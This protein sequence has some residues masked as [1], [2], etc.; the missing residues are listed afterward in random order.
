MEKSLTHPQKVNLVTLRNPFDPKDRDI[1]V[2]PYG[3]ETLVEIAQ[4]HL[5]Q[6][7]SFA[8][9]V[10][11]RPVPEEYL[12]RVILS[13]GDY[14]VFAPR[15]G[16]GDA[17]QYLK[18]VA[19]L[20]VAVALSYAFPYGMPLWQ[21][22]AISAIAMTAASITLNYL[23]PPP[24]PKIA[25]MD[26]L[27]GDASQVFSWNP[28]TVQQQ[29]I[30]IPHAYG[31]NR[32]YGNI[33]GAYLE[34]EGDKQ[35]LN[36]LI[37]LAQGPFKR[38]WDFRINDQP[39]ENMKGIEIHTRL[40][41]L[42]QNPISFFANSKIEYPQS[43]KVAYGS[44]IVYTTIRDDFDGMEIDLSC[45]Q[46]LWYAN[47]RGG[48]D[49]H[50]IDV[51][52]R[53][54][55]IGGEWET[56][57]RQAVIKNVLVSGG[58]W[59]LGYWV[60]DGESGSK[61]W[62]QAASGG[63]GVYDHYDG[64]W[65]A[66][67]RA[68]WRWIQG[69]Y[70]DAV[71]EMHDYFT[72]GGSAQAPVR[73]TI[74]YDHVGTA[75]K[76]K[77]E[78][79]KLSADQDSSRYGD[80]L[81][82]TSVREVFYDGQTYPRRVLVGIRALAT[83]QL[84]GSLRFSCLGEGR[85]VRVWDGESWSVD[86][87]H[88]AAWVLYDIFTQPVFDNSLAVQRY[89]GIDPSRFRLADFLEL[90]GYLAESVPDGKGG[91]EERLTFNGVFDMAGSMWEA[92][93][94]ICQEARCISVKFGTSIGLAI[95][96]P[97]TPVQLFTMGNIKA[98]SFKQFWLPQQERATEIEISF[99]DGEKDFA[100]QSFLAYDKT[101]VK[102]MPPA[103]ISLLGCTS[104]SEA[105][106]QAMYRLN[107][108][109]VLKRGVS[110]AADIDAVAC[111]IGD[112]IYIQH[113]VPQWGWGNRI[114]SADANSITLDQEV[115]IEAGKSY[116]VLIRI[117]AD[118][119][120]AERTITNS[121]GTYSVLNV[122]SPFDP[123]PQKHDLYWFGWLTGESGTAKPFRVLDVSRAQELTVEITAIEYNETVFN[124]DEDEPVFETP[125]YSA[126][127]T[128]SPVL[129]LN[130]VERLL[131][132]GGAI[133]SA[134]DVYFQRPSAATFDH[135]EIW[136]AS[137]EMGG[138]NSGWRFAGN[139]PSGYLR[140]ENVSEGLIYTVKAISV[141]SLGQRENFDKAPLF[142]LFV[143]G[144][145]ALPADVAEMWFEAS[146]G[147]VKLSW[148]PIEDVDL[149]FYRIKWHPDS[150]VG[151]WPAALAV[152][153]TK[154]TSLSLPAARDGIYFV[155]AVDT[156]GN[157]S[158]NAKS[159]ITTI[160]SILAW[161]VQEEMTHGPDWPGEMTG[162]VAVAGKLFLDAGGS[163][164]DIDDI[165]AI[166]DWD[167]GLAEAPALGYYELLAVDLGSVQT[168][169]SWG[170]VVFYPV[171]LDSLF[172]DIQDF[173]AVDNFDQTNIAGVGM[174]LQIA[175]SQDGENWGDWQNFLVGDYTAQSF[176]FRLKAWSDF[177]RRYVYAESLIF[178]IDMPDR[179]EKGDDVAVPDIGLP[180]VF[181]KPFMARPQVGI[182]LQS[183]NAGDTVRLTAQSE[184]GFTVRILDSG[185]SGVA[186]TIDWRAAG[187]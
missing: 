152:A 32:H 172:D 162:M 16:D 137:R 76:W 3:Y 30:P 153:D 9:S 69:E 59:S 43:Q 11:G 169:R 107:G 130:A 50:S 164:D 56:I 133:R 13:E 120:L 7:I 83:D 67:Y 155:K 106:R 19:I 102:Q 63:A 35:Y 2:I 27:D 57:S 65:N 81:Y 131:K 37:S 41:N 34:N 101:A 91:T 33:I 184:T 24:R 64:E 40:G 62:V 165:D 42:D 78:I 114:V 122:S 85:M 95:D 26:A 150:G 25:T 22:A 134:I 116:R 138:M 17:G 112:V 175:L 170:A 163:F 77:I 48:M 60:E 90:A 80:D 1:C 97:A 52:V 21:K 129:G 180:I 159:V 160:P 58:H 8:V 104:A 182:A 109:K 111:T 149:D 183:A 39:V 38:L 87:S 141:S 98:G 88:S 148:A 125:Q 51:R 46:G 100:R 36:V 68:S 115:T 128:V 15:V 66:T 185:G 89:D 70:Y 72:L 142:S 123:I 126:L 12:S 140:I 79:T 187:Y 14:V 55:P 113:D 29:G 178:G 20:V 47:D 158:L 167:F 93:M 147:G 176:K 5:P 18:M 166:E 49:A 144:K 186:R 132:E 28:Q 44:P 103:A 151:T 161:N 127:K 173:D 61:E 23:I 135:A 171:D 108:N 143:Y 139:N 86:A 177:A 119:S 121:P 145:T 74:K 105:F 53:A 96:K 181:V 10:N 84:S 146:Q 118:D 73:K 31:I 117:S 157:E 94:K 71:T 174:R 6:G 124:S 54:K 156:S 154:G 179:I 136:Y 82:L 92:A 99:R 45:P 4:T 168:C 75:G 110:F